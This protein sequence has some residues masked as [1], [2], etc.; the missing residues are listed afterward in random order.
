[1]LFPGATILFYFVIHRK[2]V[3]LGPHLDVHQTT[4]T[5]TGVGKALYL[6]V[7]SPTCPLRNSTAMGE[8]RAEE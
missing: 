1:M 6:Q 7:A 8:R 3:P 2:Q 4:C 5:V